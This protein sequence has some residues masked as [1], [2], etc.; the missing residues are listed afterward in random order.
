LNEVS[1][2]DQRNIVTVKAEICLPPIQHIGLSLHFT[3]PRK[4][5]MNECIEKRKECR[6]E[7]SI[8]NAIY[9]NKWNNLDTEFGFHT[10]RIC[11]H[12]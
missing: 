8:Q 4:Y 11:H 10:Q 1:C 7:Y 9:K 12:I 2:A 5:T 3:V 6:I